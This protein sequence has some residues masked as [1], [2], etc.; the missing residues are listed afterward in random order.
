[1]NFVFPGF[2]WALPVL[3][4]PI[5]VHLFN[6]RKTTKI[7]FS[8]TRLLRQVKEE[9]TQKR[10]LKQYLVL[11]ARLLFLFFLV[12]AF[13]QPF[14]PAREERPAGRN[15]TIY[16]DNSFS[17]SA[18]AGE[19]LRGLDEAIAKVRE[20]IQ[21]FPLETRYCLITNDFAPFSNS[22]KTRAE[23]DDLLSQMRLS[24]LSRGQA[25]ILQRVPAESRDVFWVSDFQ[26]STLAPA[27][28]D[29][30][31][32]I[33]LVPVALQR[34]GNVLVDTVYLENPLVVSGERN[35]IHVRF[36]ND[37]DKA[38]DA[39]VAKLTLNEVQAAT[40]TL[41]IPAKGTAE[42]EFDIASELPQ[43]NTARISFN[44]FA[45]PFDNEFYFTLNF[46][47]RIRVSEIST[48]EA[49]TAIEKV[50]G[51]RDLF[52]V[53]SFQTGNVDY[54]WVSQSDWVVL[55]GVDKP[56]AALV[57]ALTAYV[58]NNGSLLLIP[59]T[60][61]DIPTYQ[62]L[63]SLPAL[64]KV[65]GAAA[66]ELQTPDYKNPMFQNVF[67]ERVTNLKMPMAKKLLDWGNDR[68]ALL[69][70]RDGSPFLS[71]VGRRYVMASPLTAGFSDF[72][73]HALFVPVMYRLA[74]WGKRQEQQPY[75][76]MGD[77]T[78]TITAD[79][80]EGEEP[81]RLSGALEM[82]PP[83]RRSAGRVVLE[84]PKFSMGTGYYYVLYQRDTLDQLAFNLLPQESRL[85]TYTAAEV[86]EQMGGG[87]N[88]A[89]FDALTAEA[90]ADDL[91]SKYQGRP[92]WK[93]MIIAALLF[94]LAEVALLRMLK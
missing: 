77:H 24:P 46:S 69:A 4:I 90:F 10:K 93:Y 75:Y 9:T 33:Q 34:V 68:S 35:R 54:S 7:F 22:F 30:T 27:P 8:N 55:N 76:A 45:V 94:L 58:A 52:R 80:L 89:P 21:V 26:K 2:L 6:F 53:R 51:N 5:I 47:E 14:L 67:E 50:Y 20:I 56:D 81:V 92:L 49:P 41:A 3:A 42:T 62:Q 91:K 18:P 79:S 88:I 37:G 19:N 74:A 12:M 15:I 1:M 85:A 63:L 44:D 13:A 64:K 32:F 39:L 72:S 70:W 17:L 59:G 57:A 82:I 29:S 60:S 28:P 11:A 40:A 87:K 16:L 31:L 43:R 78:I 71:S 73:A 61:P 48:T 25:E 65:E 86:K 23:L 83:Q 36:R 38:I 66:A 84:I